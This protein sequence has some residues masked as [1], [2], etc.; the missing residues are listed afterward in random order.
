[1]FSS[2]VSFWHY[3]CFF[4]PCE[5][6]G[7]PTISWY[8]QLLQEIHQGCCKDSCSNDWSTGLWKWTK[9]SPM[10]SLFS[11]RFQPLCTQILLP[12]FPSL[13]MPL[14]LPLVLFFNKMLQV[15]GLLWLSTQRS[16]YP[17]SPD[18][19][20]STGSF[21]QLAPLT[22][23]SSSSWRVKSLFHSRTTNLCHAAT[24]PVFPLRLQLRNW[25]SHWCRECGSWC[26]ILS[27]PDPDTPEVLSTLSPPTTP[28]VP[29]ISYVEMFKL[30]K[31]CPKAQDL[32]ESLTLKIVSV[33]VSGLPGLL[34]D[35]STGDH[36]SW[37][38]EPMSRAVFDS[39]HHI[40]HSGKSAYQRLVSWTKDV[41]LWAQSCLNCKQSKVQ[42]LSHVKSPIHHIPIPGWRFSQVH[43]DL[44]GPLPQSKEFS[45]LFT[46]TV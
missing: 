39:V 21:F 18:T 35:V 41:H 22:A 31:S 23:N 8:P 33:H 37:V 45:F 3:F 26:L 5:H 14:V 11:Q 46:I 40:S 38:P 42:S 30:Q 36:H 29:E 44:V 28:S 12:R 1:M 9:L 17:P 6:K 24:P 4:S 15:L 43:V 20:P 10:P 2:P 27:G 7:S 19:P 16:F 25:P 13:W 34:C 32:R